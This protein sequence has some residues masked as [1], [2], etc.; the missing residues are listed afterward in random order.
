MLKTG[1]F[2]DWLT[3][4]QEHAGTIPDISSQT[5]LVIDSDTGE[6][7]FESKT[8]FQVEGSYST[9]I[10]LKSHHG[11]VSMS[12]N[13]GRLGRLDNVFGHDLDGCKDICQR[14]L[15]Q[16]DLPEF[17]YGGFLQSKASEVVKNYGAR[18]SR[19]DITSNYSAGNNRNAEDFLYWLGCHKVSRSQ[20]TSY[21]VAAVLWGSTNY[22]RSIVYKK[23]D[24]IRYHLKKQKRD[25]SDSDLKYLMMLAEWCD[26]IGLV[27][28]EV[29]LKYRYLHQNGLRTW[30]LDQTDIEKVYKKLVKDMTGRIEV[31]DKT[32]SSSAYATYQR[33]CSG[34]NV[35]ARLT[36]TTFYRHRKEILSMGVD[37]ATPPKVRALNIKPRF[38]DLQAVKMPDIY[39]TTNL[40]V[41]KG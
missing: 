21:G 7:Q 3:V 22:A 14:L 31:K 40:R 23:G 25:L 2:V 38:I 15:T 36:K 26:D 32:L 20:T 4:A 35:K 8:P 10:Q 39:R 30:I 28:H 41:A 1:I 16:Y 5:Q 17:S 27:R 24:E 29:K 34:E 18:F 19:I 12:G 9:K 37:I 33:Y 11:R 6:R 13:I